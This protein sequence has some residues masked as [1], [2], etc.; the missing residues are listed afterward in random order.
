MAEN[1]QARNSIRQLF[2]S[3]AVITS[4]VLKS[5]KEAEEAQ[6]YRDYFEFSE[7]FAACPSHRMLA[8][9]RGEK[10]VYLTMDIGID[11]ET[12]FDALKTRRRL[13]APAEIFN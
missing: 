7:P 3:K 5:K 10:E 4:K 12:A 1:E 8:I 11:K 2:T 13:R 9:R 6:K